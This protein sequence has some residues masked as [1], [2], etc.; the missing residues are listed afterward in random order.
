MKIHSLS[1]H[2]YDDGGVGKVFE[3]T[4]HFWSLRGKQC[5][6]QIQYN[7]SKWWPL[8]PKLKKSKN[9]QHDSCLC[10]V[11]QVSRSP[12]IKISLE[13]ASFTPSFKPDVVM[14]F[15]WKHELG[16]KEDKKGHLGLA[17]SFECWDTFFSVLFRQLLKLYWIWLK[18][19]LPLKLKHFTHPSVNLSHCSWLQCNKLALLNPECFPAND[20]VL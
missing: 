9:T 1:T 8:L 5:C 18:H 3:S 19:C 13:T 11:I 20:Y 15:E 7:W 4:K 6:S 12:D 17:P 14:L 16:S 10:G 2:H